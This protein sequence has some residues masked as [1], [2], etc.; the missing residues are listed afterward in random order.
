MFDAI[1]R[2]APTISM[3]LTYVPVQK[4]TTP[5]KINARFFQRTQLNRPK[6]GRSQYV[7]ISIIDGNIKP[8]V[9]R[10]TAPINDMNGPICG[11]AIAMATVNPWKRKEMIF[12][13]KVKVEHY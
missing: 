8:N 3:I 6:P 4:P 1:S 7:T 5:N 2:C 9:L 10:Q 12:V 13:F 11:M